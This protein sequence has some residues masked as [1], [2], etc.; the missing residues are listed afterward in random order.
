AA[1]FGVKYIA[2][3]KDTL[4]RI[5]PAAHRTSEGAAEY[6]SMVRVDDAEAFLDRLHKSGFQIYTL[7]PAATG[8]QS[9]FQTRLAEKSVFV[10]GGEVEGI[11]GL[12]RAIKDVALHVPGTGA[13]ESLNVSVVAALAMAEFC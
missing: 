10:L 2:G 13:M 7:E 6:V 4:L 1:H 3:P 5:S 9:L 8:A 11:S 12:V